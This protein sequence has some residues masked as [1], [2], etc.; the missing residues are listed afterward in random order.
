MI[1]HH[2]N[3]LG[4]HFQ[5]R[6]VPASAEVAK[7][8]WRNKTKGTEFLKISLQPPFPLSCPSLKVKK[9]QNFIVIA[10]VY[11]ETCNKNQGFFFPSYSFSKFNRIL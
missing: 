1:H 8:L 9:T 2:Y 5:L 3:G 10:A 11:Y 6:Q 7:Q 4:T